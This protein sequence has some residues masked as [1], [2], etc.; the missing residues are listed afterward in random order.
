LEAKIP[1]YLTKNMFFKVKDHM[2]IGGT[3]NKRVF[4]VLALGSSA[5]LKSRLREKHFQS[6]LSDF[7]ALILGTG[8][9]IAKVR[10]EE[11]MII[12]QIW[13]ISSHHRYFTIRDRLQ[14][15]S[16]G[17][18]FIF[19]LNNPSSL[20]SL[21]FW[22]ESYFQNNM[23][24]SGLVL[25]GISESGRR[26]E[27]VSVEQAQSYAEFLAGCIGNVVPY[28]EVNLSGERQPDLIECMAKA[29]TEPLDKVAE[30]H[31]QNYMLALSKMQEPTLDILKN[32][33][34][35]IENKSIRVFANSNDTLILS[36]VTKN[37]SPEIVYRAIDKVT[38]LDILTSMRLMLDSK[39]QPKVLERIRKLRSMRKMGL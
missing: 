17:A 18:F 5:S 37:Q 25:V 22:V 8:I 6:S 38:N 23:H 33:H 1:T 21:P 32:H 36:L 12:L 13:D 20:E 7:H 30:E 4:K 11:T 26:Q 39:F 28:I 34:L 3:L 19:D 35:I 16:F 10:I 14:R 2:C 31:P 24:H 29:I 15:G 27:S 9:S